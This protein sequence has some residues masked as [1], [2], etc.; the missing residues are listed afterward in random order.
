M[1]SS[2]TQ[3]DQL[4]VSISK[5][6][7]I[8]MS[9]CL[10]RLHHSRNRQHL[11]SKK[12]MSFLE[13]TARYIN[14]IVPKFRPVT[15]YS[16]CFIHLSLKS[17]LKTFH[18]NL[19]KINGFLL[20]QWF[21]PKTSSTHNHTEHRNIFLFFQFHNNSSTSGQREKGSNLRKMLSP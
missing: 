17:I 8:C 2:V 9:A 13:V 10:F 1:A 7:S 15:S 12:L 5:T 18:S 19:N 11:W 3:L 4:S 16:D 21:R 14:Y 20:N 6:L